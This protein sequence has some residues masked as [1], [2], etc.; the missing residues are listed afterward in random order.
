MNNIHREKKIDWRIS[1]SILLT[2]LLSSFLTGC[3]EQLRYASKGEKETVLPD[4]WKELNESSLGFK[5]K[6][7]GQ[8]K[9]NTQFMKTDGGA[10]TVHVFEY[11]HVAFMYALTVV[12]FPPGVSDMSDPDKVLDYAVQSLID[13]HNGIISYQEPVN[14]SGYPGRRAIISLPDSSLKNARVNTIIV[15]RDNLVYRASTSGIGN[16]EYTEF[17]LNSFELTPVSY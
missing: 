7:P 6:F 8:W 4:R 10:A 11:W 15:L 17:F 2:I 12:K 9:Y 14:M 3:G 1:V 5:I 16:L 13:E